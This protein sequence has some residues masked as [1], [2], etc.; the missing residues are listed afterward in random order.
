MPP[1]GQLKLHIKSQQ[2]SCPKRRSRRDPCMEPDMVKSISLINLHYLQ[3]GIQ[4]HRRISSHWKYSAVDLSSQLHRTSVHGELLSAVFQIQR[5]EFSHPE[6]FFCD[7]AFLFFSLIPGHFRRHPIKCRREFIPG[8]ESL[9]HL[10]VQRKL[11]FFLSFLEME[12]E[13]LHCRRMAQLLIVITGRPQLDHAILSFFS[14]ALR[15][16]HFYTRGLPVC[17]RP[18]PELP[19]ID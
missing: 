9:S 11:S 13:L 15:Q 18:D 2:I 14:A 17:I 8:E 16:F 6:A 5:F 1:L 10:I 19:D 7:K 12:R 3:P 4:I